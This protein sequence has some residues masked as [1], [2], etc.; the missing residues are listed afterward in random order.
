MSAVDSRSLA[1]RGIVVTRPREQAGGLARRIEQAGGKAFIF[2]AIEIENLPELGPVLQ[3]LDRLHEFDLAVFISA[4]AV[5]KAMNLVGM[6]R[7][8]WPAALRVAAIGKGSR[9]ALLGHGIP[10]VI[11]PR[12]GA[13][14]EALLALPELE[15]V[16]G[17]RV[18]IFRGEGG[19][20]LLADTLAER[21]AQVEYAECYRRGRP[22]AEIGP[23]LAVWAR[24]EVHAVTISSAEGLANFFD[25]LGKLGQQWLRATPIFVPHPRV[26][27]EAARL[28]IREALVAGPGDEETLAG[29]VSYFGRQ[30]N[31]AK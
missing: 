7:G 21:G 22:R 3:L 15:A 4:N 8:S 18:V 2:P 14:S 31:G 24:G 27:E 6:R 19:R 28:G 23:L 26:A 29:L 30:H 16:A 25:V 13:D 17:R 5:H 1:G 9:Q 11:A 10:E 20:G 12:S